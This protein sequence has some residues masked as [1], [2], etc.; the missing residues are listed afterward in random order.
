MIEPTDAEL[1][2]LKE[3]FDK[4]PVKSTMMWDTAD[5]KIKSLP[6]EESGWDYNQSILG[7]DA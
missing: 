6:E 5:G 2:E 4:R 7:F 1:L 3:L